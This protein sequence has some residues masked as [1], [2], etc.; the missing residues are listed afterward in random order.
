MCMVD[1]AWVQPILFEQLDI[2]G[3]QPI[4]LKVWSRS[5]HMKQNSVQFVVIILSDY[6]HRDINWKI[7]LLL[8]PL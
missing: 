8:G 2:S 6:I 1:H 5:L 3:L 7:S 4:S